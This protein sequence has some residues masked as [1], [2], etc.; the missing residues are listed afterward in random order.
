MKTN[1]ATTITV[2]K[3]A[4]LVAYLL[5]IFRN[6][7]KRRNYVCESQVTNICIIVNEN[8]YYFQSPW[9][10][11]LVVE[12]YFQISFAFACKCLFVKF[13]LFFFAFYHLPCYWWI[14]ICNRHK[15]LLNRYDI[16]NCALTAFENIVKVIIFI[17]I[18]HNGS[19]VQYKKYLN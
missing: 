12:N 15:R 2:R 8:A 5:K 6:A 17:F 16:F 13:L 18:H 19:R 1:S 14:K 11:L 4:Y 3:M 7:P 9:N 10:S